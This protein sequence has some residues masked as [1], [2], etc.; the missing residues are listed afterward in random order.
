MGGGAFGDVW[1]ANICLKKQINNEYR[2]NSIDE[3]TTKL[4]HFPEED[5]EIV[6]A[7]EAKGQN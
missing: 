7:K 5:G 1:M 6:A 2:V 4:L 3:D